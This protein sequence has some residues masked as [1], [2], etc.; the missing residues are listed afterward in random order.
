MPLPDAEA[1]C[2]ALAA[3]MRGHVDP[4]ATV[5]VGIHTGGVWVTERLHAALA[6]FALFP[7]PDRNDSGGMRGRAATATTVDR[8]RALLVIVRAGADGSG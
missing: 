2:A 1:L 8:E 3:A 7:L 4:A 5:L 6:N